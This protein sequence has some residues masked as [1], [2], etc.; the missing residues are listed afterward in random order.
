MYNICENV[1]GKSAKN[2]L[3]VWIQCTSL[4]IK[5]DYHIKFNQHV[6]SNS[7]LLT[8]ILFLA[9]GNHKYKIRLIKVQSSLFKPW[10]QN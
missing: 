3:H 2:D 10:E 7:K 5:Y 6:I 4:D 1:S 8:S 9:L